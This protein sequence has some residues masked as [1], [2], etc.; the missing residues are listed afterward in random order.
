MSK[1]IMALMIST[2]MGT[3]IGVFTEAN[4][5]IKNGW[6]NTNNGWNYYENGS[7][8]TGW[9]NFGG[10]FYFLKDDGSMATGW[11][12]LDNNWY[13]MNESGEMKTGWQK[14]NGTWYFMLESGI[15]KTGWLKYSGTWYYL[16]KD[17]AMVSNTEIDGYYLGADGALVERDSGND[18]TQGEAGF[19]G[20]TMKTEKSTYEL[21]T[22]EVKVYIT[23]NSEKEAYYGLQYEIERSE[24]NNWAKV[25]FKEE[26]AFIEIAYIIEPGKIGEQVITLD[27]LEQLI[28]GKYRVVKSGGKLAAEFELQ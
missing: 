7:I 10:D 2:M 11:V 25:P 22:K 17:G 12:N 16:N 3:S 13:Y 26:P 23:N 15:M 5:D 8:R 14:I 1:K 4:A 20:I 18:S 28:P 24:N 27:N 21:S 9:L 6:L 19:K